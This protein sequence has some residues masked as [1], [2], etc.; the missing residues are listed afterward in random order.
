MVSDLFYF[1]A[2]ALVVNYRIIKHDPYE[3]VDC[4]PAVSKLCK[5]SPCGYKTLKRA[6]HEG[7][8]EIRFPV[9]GNLAE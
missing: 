9:L 1:A 7:E 3:I 5:I 4:A 2:A 8:L 6:A